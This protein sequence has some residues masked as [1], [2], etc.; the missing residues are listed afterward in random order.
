[1]TSNTRPTMNRTSRQL[2]IASTLIA[3]SSAAA[4]AVPTVVTSVEMPGCDVLAVPTNVHE[5]GDAAVFP[6]NE[7]ILTLGLGSA[8]FP[9]CPSS[10]PANAF[11][12]V[13]Q[14]T[15]VSGLTWGPVWYVA[16]PA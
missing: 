16:N 13:V 6:P 7:A 1:P 9:A 5:L 12:E 3:M 11:S 15:N 4:L 2:L 10:F 8:T 14:I